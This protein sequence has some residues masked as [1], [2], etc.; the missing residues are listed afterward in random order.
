MCYPCLMTCENCK[1]KYLYCRECGAQNLVV[2]QTCISC[3]AEFTD[4]V[5][6]AERL[7][8]AA[9]TRKAGASQPELGTKEGA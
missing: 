2:R 7:A 9:R 8:W 3:G 5:R 4:K 6:R 1:Q